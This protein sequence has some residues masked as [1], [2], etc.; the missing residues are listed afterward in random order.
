MSIRISRCPDFRFQRRNTTPVQE[1]IYLVAIFIKNIFSPGCFKSKVRNFNI[2]TVNN[3]ILHYMVLY[4]L[5][6]KIILSYYNTNIS[7]IDNLYNVCAFCNLFPVEFHIIVLGIFTILY[8]DPL[9]M[10]SL[11]IN[12]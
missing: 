6:R 3:L 8:V 4:F 5:I 9:T 7:K 2:F 10:Y 1:N 12:I 11:T